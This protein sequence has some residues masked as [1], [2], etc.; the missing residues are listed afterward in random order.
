MNLGIRL[1]DTAPGSLKERLSFA[2]AQGFTC[3]HVALSKVLPDFSMQSAP[4]KLTEEFARSV[5][6]DFADTGM[7]CAVLGCYLNLADPDETRR[8]KTQDIYRAHLHFAA[9]I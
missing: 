7:S 6:Q 3:A 1:H 9:R 8:Q 2:R 4:E 5:R